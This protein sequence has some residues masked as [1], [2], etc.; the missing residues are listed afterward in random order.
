M[1]S[2]GRWALIVAAAA[3]LVALGYRLRPATAPAPVAPAAG[4]P[5]DAAG[6]RAA[7]ETAFAGGDYA[8]AAT[9]LTTATTLAP[10]DAGG[11]SA[12]GEA[13][14]QV[15]RGVGDGALT[16]FRRALDLDPRDARARYFLAVRREQDGDHR[17]AVAEW[18][19][20]LRDA[21]AGAPWAA[22]VR[23]LIREVAARERI[24]VTLPAPTPPPAP[25]AATE[26]IPG[27][28]AAQLQDAA[29]LSPTEQDAMARA[30]VD[31]LAARLRD[32]PRDATGWMRLMRARLVLGNRAGAAK[33]LTDARAAFRSDAAALAQLDGAARDLGL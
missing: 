3:L 29:R 14:V 18:Q 32:N 1:A 27:P 24:P 33:A 7:G 12:L 6:L 4:A 15:E 26:A 20:L 23:E 19:A 22:S 10:G 2:I 11:W 21:P 25:T 16:A 28:S 13:R 31:R 30:M 9:A 17:G 5:T 8:R